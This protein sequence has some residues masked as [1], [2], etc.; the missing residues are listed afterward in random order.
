MKHALVLGGTGM[1]GAPVV[2]HLV[3]EGFAVRVLTRDPDRARSVFA[4]DDIEYVRGDVVDRDAVLGAA[5]DADLVHVSVGPPHDRLSAHNAAV[6]ARA[7]GAHRL[8]YISG[9]TV[10]EAHAW[11][12]MIQGKLEAE[13]AVEESGVPWTILRPSWPYEQ[14]PRFARGGK[15]F[16]LGEIP[17]RWHWFAAEELGRMVHAAFESPA[18]VGKR[19]T[20]HGP[21]AMTLREALERYC[22]AV[23]PD[24]PP[25]SAMPLWMAKLMGVLTRNARLRFAA[26]L[27]SYFVKTGE[28]GDPSE[29]NALLGAPA[30]TLDEWIRGISGASSRTDPRATGS[31]V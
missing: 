30:L 3:R 2:R 29:A 19:L 23:H 13:R 4:T 21:E 5:L 20:I 12:P 11:Y 6:A 18:A 25:I 27:M 14:L 10:E 9:T 15:P 31:G 1:L 16:L 24:A 28:G 8:T 7:V 17:H 22:A 26:D